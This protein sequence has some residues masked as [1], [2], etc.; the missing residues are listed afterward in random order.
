MVLV[1]GPL[2]FILF[3]LQVVD[4]I[5]PIPDIQNK[6]GID[7]TWLYIGVHFSTLEAQI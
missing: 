6:I 3:I 1:L 5:W 7:D 2:L 4:V